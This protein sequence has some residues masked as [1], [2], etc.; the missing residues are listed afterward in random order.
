[1][2]IVLGNNSFT[3]LPSVIDDY[4]TPEHD[5][6]RDSDIAHSML[7]TDPGPSYD[8]VKMQQLGSDPGSGRTFLFIPDRLDIPDSLRGDIAS[9]PQFYLS[10]L[11]SASL[12]NNTDCVQS[13]TSGD[14]RLVREDC[15]SALGECNFETKRIPPYFIYIYLYFLI[16]DAILFGRSN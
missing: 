7:L 15:Y 9:S 10:T 11:L 16:N 12:R 1:M 14:L 5:H 8:L 2:N 3:L 6:H 4:F 13:L